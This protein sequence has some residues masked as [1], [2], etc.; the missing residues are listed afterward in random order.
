MIRTAWTFL[1][2][3][4]LILHIVHTSNASPAGKEPSSSLSSRDVIVDIYLNIDFLESPQKITVHERLDMRAKPGPRFEK[5]LRSLYN[6]MYWSRYLPEEVF[7]DYY[8]RS[9]TVAHAHVVYAAPDVRCHFE[10]MSS[11]STPDLS[12]RDFGPSAKRVRFT[13]PFEADML[14]C[15]YLNA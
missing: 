3:I 9:M 4:L 14:R 5:D 2:T 12:S 6:Y 10:K 8:E 1:Y 7:E 13:P 15:S 11:D